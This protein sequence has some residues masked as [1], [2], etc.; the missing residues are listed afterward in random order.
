[1]SCFHNS[2]RVDPI[3]FYVFNYLNESWKGKP[4]KE[5]THKA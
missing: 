3:I 4:C 2:A 1:M 5:F